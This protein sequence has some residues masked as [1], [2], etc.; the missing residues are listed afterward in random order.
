MFEINFNGQEILDYYKN[1]RKAYKDGEYDFTFE[2]RFLIYHSVLCH[3]LHY[4][5]LDTT[6]G[7]SSEV[8]RRKLSNDS[9]I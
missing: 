9:V 5:A 3:E 8:T 4:L 7:L 1:E 2:N 6:T